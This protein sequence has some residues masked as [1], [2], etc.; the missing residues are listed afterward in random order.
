MTWRVSSGSRLT[1]SSRCCARW[2]FRFA[3]ICRCLP[4]IRCPVFAPGGSARSACA[5]KKRSPLPRRR[6]AAADLVQ[7]PRLRRRPPWPTWKRRRPR[8]GDVVPLR[9]IATLVTSAARMI[10]PPTVSPRRSL[11]RRGKPQ[12]SQTVSRPSRPPRRQACQRRAR[13]RRAPTLNPFP[14]NAPLSSLRPLPR[15]RQSVSRRPSL[16]RRWWLR[17]WS[18]RAWSRLRSRRRLPCTPTGHAWRQL[19]VSRRPWRPGRLRSLSVLHPS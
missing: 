6:P 19:P 15:P 9:S 8:Y 14:S 17:R 4:T 10:T 18:R 12:P 1:R 2:T 7:R 5:L 13:Q 11:K 16:N 3:A